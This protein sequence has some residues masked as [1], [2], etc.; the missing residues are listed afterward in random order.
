MKK[1]IRMEQVE[2]EPMLMGDAY[3]KGLLQKGRV[4]AESKK[5]FIGYHVRS[6]DGYES[7]SPAELFERTYML[8]DASLDRLKFID[9][10]I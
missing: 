10:E 2:A 7:W 8:V 4:P 3:E 9:S 6:S 1:Y 5:D